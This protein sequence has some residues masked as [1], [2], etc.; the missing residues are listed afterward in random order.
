[1]VALGMASGWEG[2]V[3]ISEL[4]FLSG[5]VVYHETLFSTFHEDF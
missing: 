5:L 4:D 2:K 1:M 3:G